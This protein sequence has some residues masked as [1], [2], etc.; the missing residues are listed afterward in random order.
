MFAALGR[1]DSNCTASITLSGCHV[2][3]EFNHQ[4]CC[5]FGICLY[6]FVKLHCFQAKKLEWKKS[7]AELSQRIKL[8]NLRTWKTCLQVTLIKCLQWDEAEH[9]N[10]LT[11]NKLSDAI[12]WMSFANFSPLSFPRF[13]KHQRKTSFSFC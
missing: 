5:Y 1:M 10:S 13:E 7:Q 4:K 9:L 2:S 6:S 12:A 8:S 3:W 11:E